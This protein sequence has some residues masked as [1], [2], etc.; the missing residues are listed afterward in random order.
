[1]L[2]VGSK[3]IPKWRDGTIFTYEDGYGN[4][5]VG[6]G[7]FW[8]CERSGRWHCLPFTGFPNAN[9]PNEYYEDLFVENSAHLGDTLKKT[10]QCSWGEFLEDLSEVLKIRSPKTSDKILKASNNFLAQH[11]IE[12]SKM[13]QQAKN[14]EH[15]MQGSRIKNQA[16]HWKKLF[17]EC[18]STWAPRTLHPLLLDPDSRASA[19]PDDK[20]RALEQ[21]NAQ[22]RQE[23][24]DYRERIGAV[25]SGLNTTNVA[26]KAD[27]PSADKVLGGYDKLSSRIM[28]KYDD[29][30]YSNESGAN[31]VLQLR[32]AENLAMVLERMWQSIY[33]WYKKI[34]KGLHHC[35]NPKDMTITD[36]EECDHHCR[37]H[38]KPLFIPVL[39]GIT[40]TLTKHETA[41]H[42]YEK[43]TLGGEINDNPSAED[44]PN[45]TANNHTH[46]PDTSENS[47]AG[48]IAEIWEQWDKE[49]LS[50][51]CRTS[52]DPNKTCNEAQTSQYGIEWFLEQV[53]DDNLTDL[54]ETIILLFLQRP[55]LGILPGEIVHAEFDFEEYSVYDDNE[56]EEGKTA[57][58]ILPPLYCVAENSADEEALLGGYQGKRGDILRKGVLDQ[59]GEN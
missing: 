27:F 51:Q 3:N 11:K 32:F 54:W 28:D 5:T 46:H 38:W 15:G 6:V 42:V 12:F 25:S 2:P 56:I 30:V 53:G 21:E 10:S 52:A 1:M 14:H 35:G 50:K 37:K 18:I 7:T 20:I 9:D 41:D 22:L 44:A 33:S 17:T 19:Q 34:I 39:D 36:L 16:V 45:P 29:A 4:L 40:S 8:Y 47:C 26:N 57:I 13:F 43:S 59:L 23:L 31:R 48:L 49:S 58:A 24:V 55:I